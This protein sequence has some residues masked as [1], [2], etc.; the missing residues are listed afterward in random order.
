MV[1]EDTVYSTAWKPVKTI[2]RNTVE[3]KPYKDPDLIPCIKEWWA[4]VTVTP[5]D[6][7]KMVFN[8]GS[9]NGFIAS[10]PKGGHFAPNSIV[11]DKAL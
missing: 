8:K 7:K 9:S 6:N 1:K 2:A 3:I 11:G 5:D 4:Y 10:I